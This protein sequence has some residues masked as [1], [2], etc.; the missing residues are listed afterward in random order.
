MKSKKEMD[1]SDDELSSIF[2][3]LSVSEQIVPVIESDLIGGSAPSGRSAP[4][5]VQEGMDELIE[6]ARMFAEEEMAQAKSQ[7]AE[8]GAAN[9]RSYDDVCDDLDDSGYDGD[10]EGNEDSELDEIGAG[11]DR[12]KKMRID[13]EGRDSGI[14]SADTEAFAGNATHAP[15]HLLP[16]GEGNE[17]LGEDMDLE[18]TVCSG[19]VEQ[20]VN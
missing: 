2:D 3:R 15:Y 9:K 4:R 17:G 6:D 11:N 5:T 10:N 12:S 7:V 16:I 8:T 19:V 1:S 20:S 13:E 14:R 18:D